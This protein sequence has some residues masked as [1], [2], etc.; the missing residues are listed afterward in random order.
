VSRLNAVTFT[1]GLVDRAAHRRTD[2]GLITDLVA[3]P[4]TR[5]IELAGDEFAV[6]DDGDL[7][8]R[9]PR[10]EDADAELVV[11]LGEAPLRDGRPDSGATTA[12]LLVL[13]SS[14][15]ATTSQTG[16]RRAGLRE[17]AGTLEPDTAA[18]VATSLGLANWHR[19]HPRCSR[20]GALTDPVLAG[21][22]RRCPEDGSD[23]YPRTD[24]AVIMAVTDDAD[25]LLLGRAP[26]WPPGRMSVLAGFVEPGE[27]LAQAVAR[28]VREEVGIAVRDMRYVADQ[29]WPFPSS[30]MVGFTARAVQTELVLDPAEIAEAR[31]VRR[32]EVHD[33][34]ARGEYRPS[35]GFS[36]SRALVEDWFGGPLPSAPAAP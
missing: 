20:C 34:I 23:H 2:P 21:W 31:W 16:A 12:Y 27:T 36:I 24:I 33:L 3:D 8:V 35:P 14:A 29:P 28:E 5:V 1:G 7:A 17:L 25:R 13:P 22:I 32:D 15:S 6:T 30:L 10:P 9:P 11:F 19:S 26:S 4:S 18:L